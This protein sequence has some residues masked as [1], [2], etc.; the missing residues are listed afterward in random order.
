MALTELQVVPDIPTPFIVCCD[1]CQASHVS[2]KQ[3]PVLRL[4]HPWVNVPINQYLFTDPYGI[5][6][7][8]KVIDMVHIYITDDNGDLMSLEKTKLRCTLRL[9]KYSI[10]TQS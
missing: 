2:D 4:I 1:L 9:R 8:Q 5:Q 7:K 3:L 10:L 6:I